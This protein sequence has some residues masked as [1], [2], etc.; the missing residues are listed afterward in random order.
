MNRTQR[1]AIEAQPWLAI[2]AALVTIGVLPKGW[3]KTIGAL[4]SI[5]W[6]V[7]RL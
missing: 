4:G 7:S 6:L 5:A 2:A 3:Q 1:T